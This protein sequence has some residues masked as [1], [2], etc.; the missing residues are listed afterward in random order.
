MKKTGFA[1]FLLIILIVISLILSYFKFSI[2][3]N[4]YITEIPVENSTSQAIHL[5]LTEIVNN[6]NND[7]LITQ[8][9]NQNIDI[10]A[11]LK[12]YSIFVSEQTDMVVTYEFS[13][14]NMNLS[15][16]IDNDEKNIEKFNRVAFIMIKAVQER[17]NNIANIDENSIQSF[18]QGEKQFDGMSIVKEKEKIK[19]IINITK[20]ISLES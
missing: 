9:R 13:Y 18:L 7:D 12:N 14:S 3:H 4:Q 8:Y 1:W 2:D 6:F 20:K 11:V 5:A 19:M 10:N 15:I 17:M 16:V